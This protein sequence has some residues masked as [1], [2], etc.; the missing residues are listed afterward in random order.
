MTLEHGISVVICCYNSEPRI[1]AT[2]KHLALQDITGKFECEIIV[3]NNAST[4]ETEAVVNQVWYECGNPYPLKII[5][6]E[7][8]GLAFARK[9]GVKEAKFSYGVFCDDDNWLAADYLS[10]VF[11]IF[12]TKGKVGIVGGCSTPVFNS[13]GPAWFYTNCKIYAVGIQANQTGDITYRGYI[14]G[15]GMGFRTWLLQEI[16]ESGFDPLVSDRKK[17]ALTSG[18]DGEISS[19][20]IFAGYRLWYDQAL[21]FQH[22]IPETRLTYSYYEKLVAG[23]KLD[24]T[25]SVYRNYIIFKYG[26][27]DNPLEQKFPIVFPIAIRIIAVIILTRNINVIL[28]FRKLEKFITKTR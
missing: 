16:F 26:I 27:F 2:L 17:D 23:F 14:W 24:K 13:V 3:V 6:E 20:F 22:Y 4:D 9:C 18:G 1:Q 5:F 12:E 15:A 7:N 25:F 10:R 8:P 11:E 19:W 28:S 21:V